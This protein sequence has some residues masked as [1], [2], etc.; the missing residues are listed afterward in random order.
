[1][2]RVEPHVRVT[3]LH[4]PAGDRLRHHVPRREVGQL[5]DTLHESVSLP[6]DEERA[7]TAHRLGDQRLLAP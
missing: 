1:M 4:H 7:L 2:P 3:G 6:V 5:V